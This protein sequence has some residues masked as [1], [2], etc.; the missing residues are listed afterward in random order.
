MR[1]RKKKITLDRTAKARKALMRNLAAQ[2]FL[3]EKIKTTEAK[4]KALRPYVERLITRGKTNTLTTRRYLQSY[5]PVDNAIKKLLE[6]ISPRYQQ[7]YG[8]YTRIVKLG[9]RD[10]D[11]A[12]TARIELL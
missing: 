6:D 4:A 9:R 3:Y 1:H 5:L 11:G 10:G 7:R 8:G 2:F 12:K